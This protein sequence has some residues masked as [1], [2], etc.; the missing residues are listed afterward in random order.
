MKKGLIIVISLILSS[1]AS[2]KKSEGKE[3][4]DITNIDFEKEALINYNQDE[5]YY[6][7]F[8]QSI[9]I[10]DSL[11]EETIQRASD[12]DIEI[13]KVVGEKDAISNLASMCYKKSFQKA[14]DSIDNLYRR[15]QKHPGYWNHVGNCYLLMGQLRKADLFYKQA[16]KYNK[17]YAP[18]YNNIGNIHIRRKEYEKALAAFKKAH[19]LKKSSLTPAYNLAQIYLNFGV[20]SKAQKLLL[21]IENQRSGDHSVLGALATTYLFQGKA[22]KALSHFRQI[23][24]DKL[25]DPSIGLNYSVALA[26]SGDR[27]KA[28]KVFDD[29][30]NNREEWRQYYLKVKS[31]VRKL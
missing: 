28:A 2:K 22:Q 16:L 7:I 3:I 8:G 12:A 17:N 23:S 19:E 10:E 11:I 5:D 31:F 15:Y 21:Q 24:A 30:D 25:S 13:E 27:K 26:V 6:D 18:A 14:F 1:C 29:V 4:D 20:V 9:K